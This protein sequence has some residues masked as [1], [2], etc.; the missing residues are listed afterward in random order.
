MYKYVV[1]DK[2]K[3]GVGC[4]T[5]LNLVAVRPTSTT[6]QLTKYSFRVVA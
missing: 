5:H 1:L 6:V 3:P 2:E 4:I